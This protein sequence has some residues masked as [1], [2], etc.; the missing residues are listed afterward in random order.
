MSQFT[1][2]VEPSI[3]GLFRFLPFLYLI[4]FD[5]Y[6]C[7]LRLLLRSFP[8]CSLLISSPP[9]LNLLLPIQLLLIST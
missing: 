6:L 8:V 1:I 9:V 7:L 4:L 3:E 5:H 2:L